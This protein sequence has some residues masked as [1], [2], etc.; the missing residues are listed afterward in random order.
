MKTR[1]G[2]LTLSLALL[3]LLAVV[4][5]ASAA[6]APAGSTYSEVYFPSRDGT[7]L[8]GDLL[9]PTA[10]CPAGGCPV[11]V[12][13]GPYYGH[14]TQGGVL[15]GVPPSTA[16]GPSSRFF[17]FVAYNFPGRGNVF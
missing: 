14:S 6:T 3:S 2:L 8:H 5:S 10:G 13:I 7:M 12:S 15:P 4:P 11:I 9:K 17:D 16:A 1:L